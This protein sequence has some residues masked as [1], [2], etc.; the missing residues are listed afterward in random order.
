MREARTLQGI[1]SEGER[2]ISF[3]RLHQCPST[4]HVKGLSDEAV[5]LPWRKRFIFGNSDSL[6]LMKTATVLHSQQT[7]VPLCDHVD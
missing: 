1:T 7:K 2:K 4:S 3:H 5:E 6:E